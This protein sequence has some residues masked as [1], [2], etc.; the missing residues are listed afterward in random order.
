[1][2]DITNIVLAHMMSQRDPRV[3]LLD[4]MPLTNCSFYEDKVHHPHLTI[5]HVL[6][7]LSKE[8]PQLTERI[9]EVCPH[10]CEALTA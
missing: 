7:F 9:V 5:D 6:L 10:L 1:M 4:V 2:I 3:R 8:C